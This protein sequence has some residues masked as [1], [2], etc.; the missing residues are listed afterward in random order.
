MP[1][2]IVQQALQ[3][4]QRRVQQTSQHALQSAQRRAL[5]YPQVLAPGLASAAVRAITSG[6]SSSARPIPK[7][8]PH[9]AVSRRPQ[10]GLHIGQPG[11]RYIPAAPTNGRTSG[12]V[13]AQYAA[14]PAAPTSKVDNTLS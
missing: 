7:P 9:T 1:M 13:A 14:A 2:T 8:N 10:H 12:I 6:S 5:T 3:S 11:E 4:A